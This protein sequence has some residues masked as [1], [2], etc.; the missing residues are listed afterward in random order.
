MSAWA[1]SGAVEPPLEIEGLRFGWGEGAPALRDCRLRIPGPGLWMLVGSNGSGKS[2]LLRLIAGLLTPTAGHIT[3]QGRPALVFQ[4]PDHQLLLPSCGSDL[5]LALPEGLDDAARAARVASALAQVGLAGLQQRPIHTLSGG[6]K[7]RLAIAGALA[8]AATLRNANAYD[9]IWTLLHEFQP[10]ALFLL[11]EGY[12]KLPEELLTQSGVRASLQHR[13]TRSEKVGAD[14]ELHFDGQAKP[15]VARKIILALPR[16]A[17]EAIEFGD[18]VL[19]PS[20]ISDELTSVLQVPAC[21]LFL[22]YDDPWWIDA[23]AGKDSGAL[24]GLRISS[25]DLP[26]RLCFFFGAPNKGDRSVILATYADDVAAS[27]W[28]G[29][30]SSDYC[31][32]SELVSSED[33]ILC[34]PDAMIEAAE[35]QLSAMFPLPT[36]VGKAVDAAFCDWSDAPFGAAWHAW[37]AYKKSWEVAERVRRP[38]PAQ[39]LYICGEAYSTPPQ[40]WVEGAINS[41]EAMLAA[42][43]KLG[44]PDWVSDSA[45]EFEI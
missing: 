5:Q 31:R 33:A 23:D 30:R 27:F 14:Y 35:R 6:Q 9:T 37:K 43:F 26:M 45:Y 2:T 1:P 40:G 4:N 38:D 28:K 22:V 34:A 17:L 18:G 29:L 13:L 42:H 41:A 39:H 12:Q 44:R 36:E 16:A 21:K 3:C 19:A 15:I 10:Q 8:S 24:G 11:E 20:F 25:T 32:R 7:Q